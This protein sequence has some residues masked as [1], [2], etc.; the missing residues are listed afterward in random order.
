MLPATALGRDG[1][2][3]RTA[4][5]NR[6][7]NARHDDDSDVVEGDVC[8]RLR[9]E[10]E[11]LV[12]HEEMAFVG[13]DAAFDSCLPMVAEEVLGRRDDLLSNQATEDLGNDRM[14]GSFVAWRQLVFVFVFQ[15][16]PSIQVSPLLSTK[17]TGNLLS[18]VQLDDHLLFTLELH[19][20]ERI[21]SLALTKGRI[22]PDDDEG[23]QVVR[24]WEQHELFD[25]VVL[26]LV[27]VGFAAETEGV[28][29]H[30]DVK[31]SSARM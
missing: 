13:F 5:R 10:H 22:K 1:Y 8:R 25:V 4:S 3:E 24:L 15:Q 21:P 29:V 19:H 17:I 28:F 20:Q 27:V 12:Q 16:F 14:L 30:V 6:T 11:A 18:H 9:N 2:V 26:D 31:A 23:V 7:T